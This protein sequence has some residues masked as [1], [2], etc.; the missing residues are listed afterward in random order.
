MRNTRLAWGLAIAL[1]PMFTGCAMFQG[2]PL[3]TLAD[4]CTYKKLTDDSV[5]AASDGAKKFLVTTGDLVK[6]KKGCA[7]KS[8]F[9][10]YISPRPIVLDVGR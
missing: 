3:M 10:H 2:D 8:E 7:E 9:H 1:T 6:I 4:A 5:E